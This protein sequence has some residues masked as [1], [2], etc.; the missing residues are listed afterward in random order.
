MGDG[1]NDVGLSRKHVNSGCEASLRRLG[2]DYV[3]LY[4]A[5]A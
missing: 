5:H 2:T 3:D 1:P 4:Q